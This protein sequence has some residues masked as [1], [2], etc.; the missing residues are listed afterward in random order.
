MVA[1]EQV[2][3]PEEGVASHRTSTE[4]E[5]P[6]ELNSIKVNGSVEFCV[7]ESRIFR[8]GGN[9]LVE[10]IWRFA[11]KARYLAAVDPCKI[12]PAA[13]ARSP[14]V[15]SATNRDTDERCFIKKF[16]PI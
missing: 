4:I 13:K 11:A 15:K 3:R 2:H 16:C 8:E 1:A 14:P 10:L 5:F 12:S 6:R 7:E 9:P